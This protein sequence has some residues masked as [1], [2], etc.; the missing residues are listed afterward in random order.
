MSRIE[1]G[2]V[3]PRYESMHLK[4][5]LYSVALNNFL[6]QMQQTVPNLT[7][8]KVQGLKREETF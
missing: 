2:A 3:L 7:K 6:F 4:N 5:I 8:N 1:Q